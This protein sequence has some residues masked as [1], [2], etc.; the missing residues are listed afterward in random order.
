MKVKGGDESATVEDRAT[1]L[2]GF[3]TRTFK[4]SVLKDRHEGL[5]YYQVTLILY[6][7]GNKRPSELL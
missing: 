2:N 1:R 4:D 5:L 3:I 7:V 6:T